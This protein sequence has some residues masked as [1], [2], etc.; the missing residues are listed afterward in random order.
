[1]VSR[2]SFLSALVL[3]VFLAGCAGDPEPVP[4]GNRYREVR[5]DWLGRQSFRITSALGTTIIT[6]PYA[7]GF[8]SGQKP[9]IVLITTERSDA[10][11]VDAFDNS[12]TVF[13]GAVGAGLNNATGIRFRGVPTYK[14]PE[15]ETPDAMNLVFAWTLDGMRFCF[16][17]HLLHPL[18]PAQVAQI[19]TVDVL[20]VPPG[21]AGATAVSQL[22]PRVIIPMGGGANFPKIYRL[23]ESSVLLTKETLPVEQTALIFSNP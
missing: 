6:N 16:L 4:T 18:T 13:R 20:F 3:S 9:D 12:P 5:V 23:P 8:P 21:N 22:Q 7:S 11:N 1:M 2:I 19:G 17:G 10:N 15:V 14:N